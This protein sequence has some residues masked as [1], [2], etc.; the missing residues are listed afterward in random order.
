MSGL[1]INIGLINDGNRLWA[2]RRQL[3]PAMG[4]QAGEKAGVEIIKVCTELGVKEVSAFI[5]STENIKYRSKEELG[6][7]LKAGMDFIRRMQDEVGVF[8]N[9]F[10]DFR[11]FPNSIQDFL[12]AVQEKNPKSFL[13][14]VNLGIN[15]GGIWD[16]TEGARN[17]ARAVR[18]KKLEPEQIDEKVFHR[19]LPTH[20]VAPMDLLIRTK[21]RHCISNFLLWQVPYTEIIFTPTLWPDFTS[22]ELKRIIDW[23]LRQERKF[24]REFVK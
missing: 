13:I 22:D 23:F 9:I 21:G 3:S 14:K 6:A 18:L 15:Y 5:S 8:L 4:Y 19:H 24:G 1:N 20:D 10:G 11:V 7:V 2:K 16:L 12:L 17:I